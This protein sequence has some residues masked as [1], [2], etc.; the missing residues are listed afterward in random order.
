MAEPRVPGSREPITLPCGELVG[1][2]DVDMGMRELDC[3]CGASHGVVTDV[4]PPERFLPAEI[5][6]VLRDVVEV[7]DGFG[8]F[9][10]PHLMASVREEY[11]EAVAVADASDD[12]TVGYAILWVTD[13]DSRRLHE[14][15]VELVVELM[16][17]AMSHAGD[18][19]AMAAFEAEMLDFDVAAFVSEYRAERDLA[20]EDVPGYERG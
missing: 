9:G 13:F 2:R 17:H 12:G 19:G 3:E 16:E 14:L 15:V 20:A 11:P 10:T 18:D 7:T 5:V 1:V 6:A 4:H 8:E